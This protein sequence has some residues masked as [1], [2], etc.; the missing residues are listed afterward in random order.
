M[1]K[2]KRQIISARGAGDEDMFTAKSVLLRRQ[3][4][5][6]N[7]FSKA[8]GLLTQNERTQVYGFDRSAASK[9]SW[10]AWKGVDKSGNGGII[11]SGAISGALNPYSEKAQ[12]HAEQ[13]YESVRH[14]KT[15]TQK[16]SIATGIK[17]VRL[18]K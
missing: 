9:A 8:A 5:E 11:N 1:R 4:E 13:Y 18:I 2:T 3:K 17:K 16:I 6:Y 12:K 7:K 10:A 14:M 15:D